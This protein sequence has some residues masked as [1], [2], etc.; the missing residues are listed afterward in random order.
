MNAFWSYHLQDFNQGNYSSLF[1][2]LGDCRNLP[3]LGCL[4]FGSLR[5]HEQQVRV[6]LKV[7]HCFPN[8]VFLTQRPQEFGYMQEA[9]PFNVGVLAA[10]KKKQIYSVK[11]LRD[12]ICTTKFKNFSK[13]LQTST[14]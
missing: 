13:D 11:L 12:K 2:L 8:E 5:I 7:I 10:E 6:G 3:L 4:V 14:V 9:V 1:L